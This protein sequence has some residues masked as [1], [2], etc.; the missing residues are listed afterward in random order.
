MQPLVSARKNSAVGLL[1]GIGIGFAG[2]IIKPTAGNLS[3]FFLEYDLTDL[4]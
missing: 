4:E 3:P 1:K 2:L